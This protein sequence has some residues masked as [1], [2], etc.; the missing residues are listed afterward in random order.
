MAVGTVED[1]AD[2]ALEGGRFVPGGERE[3]EASAEQRVLGEGGE[4]GCVSLAGGG[5]AEDAVVAGQL[6]LLAEAVLDPEQRRAQGEESEGELLD[7]VRPV[8]VTTKML[9][10]VTHDGFQLL[11]GEAGDEVLRQQDPG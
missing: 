5:G 6:A 1:V 4:A 3:G 2:A 11:G 9:Q 7:Q 8:V 10:L